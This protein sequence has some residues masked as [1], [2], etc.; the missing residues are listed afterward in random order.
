MSENF[1]LEQL[2]ISKTCLLHLPEDKI[3]LP[4]IS[5]HF[6]DFFRLL[7]SPIKKKAL[8]E[9]ALLERVANH[10]SIYFASD[11]ASYSTARK[12]TLKLIP[13]PRVL[14]GFQKDYG[15][16]EPM[17]FRDIPEWELILK[18]IEEFEREFNKAN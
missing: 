2:P 3:L 8:E 18:T 12:G 16:M 4:R 13:P 1:S 14:K 6:Y 5:R 7:N 11:W 10:K 15:L 9:T 17:L